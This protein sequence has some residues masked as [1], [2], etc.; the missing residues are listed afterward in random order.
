MTTR[1]TRPTSLAQ[2]PALRVK[3]VDAGRIR[4]EPHRVALLQAELANC[5]R[6]YPV[7]LRDVDVQ[8]GVAAEVLGGDDRSAPALTVTARHP[9]LWP[10]PNPGRT[11]SSGKLTRPEVHAGRADETRDE[12]I[13]GPRVELEG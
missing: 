12:E 6:G 10:N 8:E 9:I 11:H 5:T 3:P 1:L 2:R 13:V 4:R 7:R